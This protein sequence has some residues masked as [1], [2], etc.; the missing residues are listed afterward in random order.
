MFRM[1]SVTCS[2]SVASLR[3]M[4]ISG[5]YFCKAILYFEFT[6]IDFVCIS[7][8]LSVIRREESASTNLACNRWFHIKVL[9][10]FWFHLIIIGQTRPQ[11]LPWMFSKSSGVI[12]LP[13]RVLIKWRAFKYISVVYKGR[14]LTFHNFVSIPIICSYTDTMCLSLRTFTIIKRWQFEVFF[15]FKHVLTWRI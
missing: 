1:H 4:I 10:A 15:R 3:F 11:I 8:C 6:I 7:T 2:L 13:I 14:I 12:N 5:I 9:I